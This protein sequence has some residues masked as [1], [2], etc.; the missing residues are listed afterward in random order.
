MPASALEKY[1]E[2]VTTFMPDSCGLDLGYRCRI[3]H[4]RD[5]ASALLNTCSDEAYPLLE[6]VVRLGSMAWTLADTDRLIAIDVA[7]YRLLRT[8]KD[9]EK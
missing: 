6:H 5:T 8:V 2:T 1:R 4:A 7:L 9:M 3:C